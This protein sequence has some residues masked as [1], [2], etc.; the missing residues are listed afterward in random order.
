MS[1]DVGKTN[2]REL[3]ALLGSTGT[4]ALAG[5][6]GT[7]DED[8]GDDDDDGGGPETDD[9]GSDGG[10]PE[11]TD[12]TDETSETEDEEIQDSGEIDDYVFEGSGQEVHEDIQIEGGLTVIE[13]TH[14]GEDNFQ[15]ALE[16]GFGA[17]QTLIDEIGDFDGAQ[18]ELVEENEYSLDVNADGEWEI[19][20][21]QPRATE[22]EALPVTL[23]G[24]GSQVYGP[25]QFEGG[26]AATGTHSGEGL[27]QVRIMPMEGEFSENVFNEDGEFEEETT[28]TF[29][30]TDN[31]IGWVDILADG[32]WELEF[33]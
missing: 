27:F 9:E 1:N 32:Q 17:G 24:E 5:C 11:D 22:G 2:R 19:T 18:A 20:I 23:S 31:N 21:R 6:T 13:A 15:V 3:L 14:D 16:P 10:D 12:D 29:D 7:D 30:F 4:L 28:Y 25:V 26:G 33:E 8:T